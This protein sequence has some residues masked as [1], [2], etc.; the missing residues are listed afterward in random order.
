MSA[1]G[2][3]STFIFY[4]KAKRHIIVPKP[5]TTSSSLQDLR[6]KS[7]NPADND[8]SHRSINVLLVEDNLVNQQILVKQLHKAGCTVTVANHG[9]EAL[10]KLRIFDCWSQADESTA[11]LPLDFILMDWEMPVMGGIECTQQI[12][13]QEQEGLITR[14][15]QII[16]VTANSRPEQIRIATAAGMDSVLPKPFI[17]KDLI[18]LMRSNL[19]KSGDETS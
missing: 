7:P 13:K 9:G 18:S 12:R 16:G 2:E 4:I 17:V 11:Q 14:H 1:K 19:V 8:T 3:G 10:E 6:Q 5:L 15:I